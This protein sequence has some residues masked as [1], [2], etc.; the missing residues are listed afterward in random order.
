MKSYF[1]YIFPFFFRLVVHIYLIVRC[2]QFQDKPPSPTPPVVEKLQLPPGNPPGPPPLN[3]KG[4]EYFILNCIYTPDF[5]S[6]T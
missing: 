2:T 3:S 1:L 6:N 5:R 4:R